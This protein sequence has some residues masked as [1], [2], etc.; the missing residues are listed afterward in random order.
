MKKIKIILSILIACFFIASTIIV[1]AASFSGGG[2]SRSSSS[3]V[4]GGNSSH[5]APTPK[6][7]ID[8]SASSAR[9]H[10]N[11]SSKFFTYKEKTNPTPVNS[12]QY[13]KTYGSGANTPGTDYKTVYQYSRPTGYY[14]PSSTTIIYRDNYNNNFMQYATMMWMFHH[15]N[16]VDKT[17]FDDKKRMELEQRVKELESQGYKRDP[18]YVQPVPQPTQTQST[19]SDDIDGLSVFLWVVFISTVIFIILIIW[20]FYFRRPY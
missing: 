12:P 2:G 18:N 10:E 1:D 4:S 13:S 11:S 9:S 6:S 8:S 15:W 20:F 14:T 3:G 5:S 7:S 19:D 16:T 17:R